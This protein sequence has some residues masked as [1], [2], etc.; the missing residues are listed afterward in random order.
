[1]SNSS[2]SKSGNNEGKWLLGYEAKRSDRLRK[3]QEFREDCEKHHQRYAGTEIG[4]YLKNRVLVVLTTTAQPTL[5]LQASYQLPNAGGNDEPAFHAAMDV[6]ERD[7]TIWIQSCKNVSAFEHECKKTYLPR[8]FVWIQERLESGLRMRVE[9]DPTWANIEQE[10]PRS[11]LKLMTLIENVMSK[12]DSSGEGY[13][14]Y[15]SLKDLFSP[16]MVM[17]PGQSLADYEKFVRGRMRFIQ[18]KDCWMRDIHGLNGAPDR[19]ESIFDEEFFVN[20][21]VDNLSKVFDPVKIDYNNAIANS[22]ITRNTTFEDTVQ[23]L[24]EV[25]SQSGQHVAATALVTKSKKARGAKKN[26]KSKSSEKNDKTKSTDGKALQ[27]D[28]S[29]DPRRKRD[30]AHCGGQHWDSRC[31][32][33]KGGA[34]A[35]TATSPTSEEV[36]NAMKETVKP[37]LAADTLV[38][39]GDVKM[40][41]L[42]YDQI[43]EYCRFVSSQSESI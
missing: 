41:D 11:P 8:L 5:P 6:Y 28:G 20:L 42:T 30:C 24:S 40:G 16:G 34:G 19:K 13:S 39:F 12:S 18:A 26:D 23:Y 4:P 33:S 31:T 29:N 27:T 32:K 2:T 43:Q 14:R 15:E 38:T 22:S 37:K 3:F 1:M 10:N 9:S 25:R 36:K 7:K 35:K 21:M 17:K